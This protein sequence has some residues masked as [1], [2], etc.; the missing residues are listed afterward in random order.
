M[1]LS[2]F[3]SACGRAT[4]RLPALVLIVA[5]LGI[6]AAPAHEGHDH[7]PPAAAS[8]PTASPRAVAVSDQYELVAILRGHRLV[9]YLDRFADNAPVTDAGVAVTIGE[10]TEAMTAAAA[11]DGTYQLDSERFHTPG[12]LE[13]VFAITA[14]DGDDLLA[15]TLRVPA[16][17]GAEA[18]PGMI[19]SFGHWAGDKG[20]LVPAGLALGAVAFGALSLIVIRRR[21]LRRAAASAAAVTLLLVLPAG[22]A[23]GHEGHD[24]GA[25]AS[26]ASHGDAPRRLPDGSVFV[27][28][29]TQRLL[30]LRTRQVRAEQVQPSVTLIGRVIADPNRT[31]LVQ[32]INGGRVIAPEAGLPRIGQ[33]V[34]KGDLLARIE[35]ALPQ[36]D[37]T[38]IAEKMGEVEQLIAVAETKLRR[39]RELAERN[40]APQSQVADATVELEGLRR[41]R[42]VLR[43]HPTAPEA[44]RAATSGVIA[45]ARALPGQVVQAQDVLF[46]IVDPASLWVEALV[47][48][49]TD[50]RSLTEASAT[51]PAGDRLQLRIQGFSR[52]LQQQA[53]VVQFAIESP[54][55]HLSVGLP[56]TVFA[57]TGAARSA[58]VLPREALVRSAN[59]ETVVWRHVD[60][61]RFEPRPVRSMP[62]DAAHVIVAAGLS[63]GD[64]VVTRAADLVNQVR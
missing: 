45:V 4:H 36:A 2:R 40:V 27:P 22:G 49:E 17:P 39:V 55:A 54:P 34:A 24:H 62:L 43:E 7:G 57:K 50:P 64:R 32:S 20:G 8:A 26:A 60:A 18:I 10:A 52:A 12:A 11:A 42:E 46:Q 28:K 14:P 33:A 23:R 38:T 31:S 9:I 37:R 63:E 15:A 25:P 58:L 56:I 3:R 41:R 29:P 35:P 51:T 61:E 19:A 47:F 6:T 30:E 21:T 59:G 44:L 5:L 13:L 53:I 16:P 1:D 48:G